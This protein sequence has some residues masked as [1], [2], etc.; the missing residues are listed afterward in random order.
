MS[1]KW[2]KKNDYTQTPRKEQLFKI[3]T[4]KNVFHLQM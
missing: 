2:E 4:N 1:R 3:P